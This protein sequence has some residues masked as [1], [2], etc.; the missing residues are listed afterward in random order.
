MCWSLNPTSDVVKCMYSTY[1][2]IRVIKNHG[3]STGML[4]FAQD[5]I[6]HT[7]VACLSLACKHRMGLTSTD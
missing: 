5:L 4:Q 3:H 6:V 7:G 1:V 2:R